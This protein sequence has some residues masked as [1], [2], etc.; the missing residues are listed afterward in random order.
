MSNKTK[1]VFFML[2]SALGFTLMSVTV[3]YL[4]DIPLFEKVIF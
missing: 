3:K 2:I 4:G 1:A